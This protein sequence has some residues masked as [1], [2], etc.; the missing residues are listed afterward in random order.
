MRT[1]HRF[2]ALVAIAGLGAACRSRITANITLNGTPFTPTTCRSGEPM[3][4]T[5]VELADARGQ[6]L[7]I[8]AGVTGQSLVYYF[9]DANS[10]MVPMGFCGPLSIERQNSRINNVYNVR[11]NATLNCTGLGGALTGSVSFENCH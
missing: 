11:G 3:G 4:F 6:R 2:F 7:R 5:G 8:S 9:P 10:S 1:H